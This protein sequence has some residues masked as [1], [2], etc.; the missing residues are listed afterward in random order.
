VIRGATVQDIA[1][2]ADG[3]RVRSEVTPSTGPPVVTNLLVDT[4]GA[5]SQVVAESDG[6]GGLIAHYVRGDDL[7]AVIRPGGP[8]GFSTRFYHA[9]AL[10]SVRALTDEAGAVTDTYTYTAFGEL[11]AHTGP[12]PQ[13]Y[14]FAGEPYDPNVG[15]QYHRARWLDVRLGRFVGMDPL[16]GNPYDPVSLHRYLY[17]NDDPVGHVDPTGE[18]SLGSTMCSM[19]IAGTINAMATAVFSLFSGTPITLSDLWQSFAIGA[20]TAPVGGFIVRVF[21]PLIRASL[22]PLL[23]AIGAMPRITLVGRAGFSSWLVKVSRWFVNTNR[24]YPSVDSTLLGRIMKRAFPNIEWQMHHVYIQ[25]A[26]SRVGSAAQI[27]DDV[28]ANEGLRRIGNGLWNLFPIPAAMN[29]WLGS[30]L[31]ATHM[32]ATAYYSIMVFGGWHAVAAFGGLGDD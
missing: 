19:A 13:P 21:A 4:S 20:L 29:N 30:H 8:G 17:A 18:F 12:D 3:N 28:L 10:G 11:L 7:L 6:L 26:W 32:L 14:A 16:A 1:Y 15:F 2:D 23:S 5:L 24:H 22:A 27:Y 31:F 25:Q 9:D